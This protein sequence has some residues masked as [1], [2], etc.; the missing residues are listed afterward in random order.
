MPKIKTIVYN[1]KGQE[2]KT[3]LN[4]SI[5]NGGA[6]MI[7]YPEVVAVL[8]GKSFEKNV[9][10]ANACES[11]FRANIKEAEKAALVERKVIGLEFETRTG[12]YSSHGNNEEFILEI[13][14]AVAIEQSFEHGRKG[15]HYTDQPNKIPE[16]FRVRGGYQLNQGSWVFIDWTKEREKQLCIYLN[17]VDA[18][19]Q[20][21]NLVFMEIPNMEDIDQA[22]LESTLDTMDIKKELLSYVNSFKRGKDG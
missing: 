1:F 2:F 12:R 5:K 11:D 21:T 22:K 15:K 10:D 17:A 16:C 9:V 4:Y 18:V 19:R 8:L 3:N 14:A 20:F 7:D 6:F 13:R